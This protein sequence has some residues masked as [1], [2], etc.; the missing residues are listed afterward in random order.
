MS[1]RD[2]AAIDVLESFGD[3]RMAAVRI[4]SVEKAQ[5]VVVT[6]EQEARQAVDA[7]RGLMRVVAGTD[8]A[9]A[10]GQARSL[11]AGVPE[12]DSVGGRKF[13]WQCGDGGESLGY[14]ARC[15][16]ARQRRRGKCGEGSRDEAWNPPAGRREKATPLRDAGELKKV[17]REDAWQDC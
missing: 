6:V 5:A 12:R 14:G 17:A 11:D 16:E 7:E 10:H 2:F 13:A 1:T 8:S 3:V 4:G 15:R 9:G